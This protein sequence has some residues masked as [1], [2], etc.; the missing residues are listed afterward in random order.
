MLVTEMTTR[1]RYNMS[2][3]MYVSLRSM[4]REML[5]CA[6]GRSGHVHW[7]SLPSP[8]LL[9]KLQC[10]DR[11][12][13]LGWLVSRAQPRV[14][15]ADCLTCWKALSDEHCGSATVLAGRGTDVV[16]WMSSGHQLGLL[17]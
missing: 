3:Q 14:T 2:L 12:S 11:A 13:L 1:W 6:N 9:T 7:D 10:L 4:E 17:F 15:E 16:L 5:H 8:N